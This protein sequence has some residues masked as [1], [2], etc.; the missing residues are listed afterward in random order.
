MGYAL[1]FM[2][3][4]ACASSQLD[5]S[6]VAILEIPNTNIIYV[7]N[8]KPAYLKDPDGELFQSWKGLV[9]AFHFI[10]DHLHHK[11][12]LNHAPCQET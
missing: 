11:V 8:C 5:C 4:Q 6:D 7:A 1:Y 10:G 3:L 12:Y 9:T 2:L